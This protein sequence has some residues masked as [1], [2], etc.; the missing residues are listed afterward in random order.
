V[1]LCFATV[2]TEYATLPLDSLEAAKASRES[3]GYTSWADLPVKIYCL[4]PQ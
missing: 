4:S 3:D 1:L 2:N